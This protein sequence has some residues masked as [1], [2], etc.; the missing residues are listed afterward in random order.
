MPDR[1][2]TTICNNTSPCWS[3]ILFCLNSFCEFSW[4]YIKSPNRHPHWICPFLWFA[5]RIPDITVLFVHL[6]LL[7][8]Q[9]AIAV[10]LSN[11]TGMI[12]HII[13]VGLH[14]MVRDIVLVVHWIIRGRRD[15]SGREITGTVIHALQGSSLDDQVTSDVEEVMQGWTDRNNLRLEPRQAV[16]LSLDFRSYFPNRNCVRAIW[17]KG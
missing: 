13:L 14:S 12:V 10:H 11:N 17:D 15:R 5:D 9:I 3:I 2:Y 4:L 7:A 8:T 1:E 16:S 6:M